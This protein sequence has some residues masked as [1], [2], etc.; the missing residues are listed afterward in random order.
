MGVG[1]QVGPEPG[2]GEEGGDLAAEMEGDGGWEGAVLDCAG[3]EGA[4]EGGGGGEGGGDGGGGVD[5]YG[6]GGAEDGGELEEEGGEVCEGAAFDY[7][8]GVG[9]SGR[10][11]GVLW[12]VDRW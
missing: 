7:D 8:G 4:E 12:C 10:C 2:R 1:F 3:V 6:P 9:G 5:Y 11:W